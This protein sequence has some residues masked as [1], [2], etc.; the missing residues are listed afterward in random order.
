MKTPISMWPGN[1]S[2][3][4]L[5]LV[6]FGF[7][8]S[9]HC[10]WQ[11]RGGDQGGSPEASLSLPFLLLF[12]CLFTWVNQLTPVSIMKSSNSLSI[13]WKRLSTEHVTVPPYFLHT[14]VSGMR[15]PLSALASAPRVPEGGCQGVLFA[16]SSE[17]SLLW[18]AWKC[19]WVHCS[20]MASQ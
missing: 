12:K 16:K 11:V 15:P 19:F 8:N 18:H 7:P 10:R 5:T 9:G 4:C 2:Q 13:P 17:S 3:H 1:G 6:W 14:I 20:E